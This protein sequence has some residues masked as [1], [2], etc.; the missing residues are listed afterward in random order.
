MAKTL[1]EQFIDLVNEANPDLNL[2][3]ADVVFGDPAPYTP[4]AEGGT[5]NSVLTLTAKSESGTFKGSKEYH[6]TRYNLTHPN[7]E[8]TYSWQVTDIHE[9]WQDDAYAL[10]QF[11][12]NL[13]NNWPTLDDV[14]ISRWT[15]P[16]E[17]DNLYVKIKMHDTLLKWWGSFVIIV[18]DVG[19]QGLMFA[20][21]ELTGF[22]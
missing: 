8:D 18:T 7:G 15:V 22:K 21:G 9:P 20:N 11:N 19:K 5:R 13:P 12:L 2:T 16:E 3:L 10:K 17:P 14:V 4:G 6:F 1:Q